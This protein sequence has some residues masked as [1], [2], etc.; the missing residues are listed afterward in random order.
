MALGF[1]GSNGGIGEAYREFSITE[2]EE[3]IREYKELQGQCSDVKVKERY[4]GV[5]DSL[6]N[7]QKRMSRGVN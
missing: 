1:F 6:R 5:I 7:L 2:V 4:V 3:R